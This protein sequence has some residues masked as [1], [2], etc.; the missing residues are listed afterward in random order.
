MKERNDPLDRK[1]EVMDMRNLSHIV[2]AWK[3]LLSV[4]LIALCYGYF[5]GLILIYQFDVDPFR[6]FNL[7]TIGLRHLGTPT[8][9]MGVE[10]HIDPSVI[11]FAFNTV[12][13][14]G[15][16]SLLFS[17]TLLNPR[18]MDEFPAGLRKSF[19][20]D[21]TIN[22][23]SPLRGFRAIPQKH[24]RPTFVWLFAF[25]AIPLILVGLMAGGMMSS[26]HAVFG[27]LPYVAASLVPHGIFEIPALVLG[28]ALPFAAYQMVRADL[29]SGETEKVFG[30]ITQIIHS[31]AIKVSILTILLLLAVA[32]AIEGHVTAAVA[33]W[34]MPP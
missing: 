31:R 23:F 6:I 34:I 27:S 30:K 20:F 33:A 21:P 3:Y 11:I 22:I 14:L 1:R 16:A 10:L 29:E 5:G 26:A 8:I 32:S 7:S 28:A 19:I 17:S 18:R 12:A 2:K 13:T 25:P 9:T 15:I 4:F 24:L